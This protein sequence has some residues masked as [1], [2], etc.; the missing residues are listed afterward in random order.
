[1]NFQYQLPRAGSGSSLTGGATPFRGGWVLDLS[2]LASIDIDPANMLARCGPGVVVA[3]LQDQ[4]SKHGLFI[5][6]PIF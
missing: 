6:R 2:N 4:V 3:D 5:P 1:M